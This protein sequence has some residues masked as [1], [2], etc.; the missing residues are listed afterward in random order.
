MR[1]LMAT[2]YWLMENS[3]SESICR[4]SINTYDQHLRS[5]I[6]INHQR[7]EGAINDAT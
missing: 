7:F 6:T 5:T 3:L 4:F 1:T 2:G